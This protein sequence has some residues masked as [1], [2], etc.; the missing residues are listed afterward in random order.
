MALPALTLLFAAAQATCPDAATLADE[1]VQALLEV[2][3][4][5]ATS[6][7]EEAERGL[8][9]GGFA[10]PETVA[11]VWQIRGALAVF[12]GD[13]AEAAA[14]IV[15]A[16]A[17]AP[18][19]LEPALGPRVREAW[20]EA[21]TVVRGSTIIVEPDTTGRRV[22][23]D[24]LEGP[25]PARVPAGRHLVQVGV[26]EEVAFRRIVEV[27]EA[28]GVVVTTGLV[29]LPD[30]EPTVDDE[31]GAASVGLHLGLGAGLG[32]GAKLTGQAEPGE[33]IPTEPAV[34]V[35]LPLEVGLR[36]EP[37]AV[38]LRVAAQAA[39]LI[40]GQLLYA[41]SDG[42]EASLPALLGGYGAGGARVG[43]IRLGALVG[44]RLPGRLSARGVAG[45][46]LGER[47]ALEARL[48]V[49]LPTERAP[50]AVGTALFAFAL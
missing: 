5:G 28:I 39:P 26:G 7:I 43:D 38:W 10:P 37:G 24:G 14:W 31:A 13:E 45:F 34:K 42:S 50:E 29:P 36:I 18:D 3:Y 30:P 17:A 49:D 41:A 35:S 25:L 22:A 12:D 16:A 2:D 19:A 6:G 40:G 4:E 32:L 1:A 9:C 48:G 44:A 8:L 27:P 11:R 47:V 15:P 23:V 33:P 21:M 20:E 46:P